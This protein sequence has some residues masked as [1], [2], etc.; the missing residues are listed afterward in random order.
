MNSSLILDSIGFTIDTDLNLIQTRYINKYSITTEMVSFLKKNKNS[1]LYLLIKYIICQTKK[2]NKELDFNNDIHFSGLSYTGN[3]CYM[4]TTL[5]ATFLVPN[6]F[7]T[8]EIIEKNLDLSTTKKCSLEN[9]TLDKDINCRKNLQ[10]TLI[11]II[12]SIRSQKS[13]IKNVEELRKSISFCKGSEKFHKKD[14]QDAGEFLAY[15]FDKFEVESSRFITYTYGYNEDQKLYLTSKKEQSGNPIVSVRLENLSQE[16]TYIVT[17]FIKQKEYSHFD[18]EN[19]FK[20]KVNG[21]TMTFKNRLEITKTKSPFIVFYIQRLNYNEDFQ[22]IKIIPPKLMFNS[23]PTRYSVLSLSAI[24]IHTGGAH[25]ICVF[26]KDNTWY[27]FDDNP[28]SSKYKIKII[29]SY[30]QMLLTK[31]SP[32]TNGTLYYYS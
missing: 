13:S 4:D 22:T 12:T 24:V 26:K 27:W 18:N 11:E 19:L 25:Y 6:L 9:Y 30:E 5:I 8:N 29:G 17:Q 23:V 15:L 32:I 2:I 3:S 10:K 14:T 31:P 16:K 1:K 28:S 21:N 20:A 7:I